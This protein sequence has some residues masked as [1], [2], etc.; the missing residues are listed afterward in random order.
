MVIKL[1]MSFSNVARLHSVSV[2]VFET[3][4]RHCFDNICENNGN[5]QRDECLCYCPSRSAVREIGAVNKKTGGHALL[6]TRSHFRSIQW[7]AEESGRNVHLT[8]G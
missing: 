8:R 1:K 5:Q 4:E 7:D 3:L 2:C 6:I